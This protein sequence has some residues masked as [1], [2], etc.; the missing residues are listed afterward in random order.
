M[1]ICFDA[2]DEGNTKL[3]EHFKAKEF[4]CKDNSPIAFIDTHIIDL[5]EAIRNY[6]NSPVIINSGYRTY[7][8][9]KAVGGAKHSYHMK[10]MAADIYVKGVSNKDVAKKASELL[11]KKGGVICH[12]NYVHVD[13]RTTERYRKGVE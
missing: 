9:N 13:I 11:G 2:R 6:Y 12:T 7:T 5:L 10:G 1:L 8:W 3:S 4:A